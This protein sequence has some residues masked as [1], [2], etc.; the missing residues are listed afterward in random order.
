M[1]LFFFIGIK[2]W[3]ISLISQAQD[4]RIYFFSLVRIPNSIDGYF[5]FTHLLYLLIVPWIKLVLL[6]INWI[7]MMLAESCI[8]AHHLLLWISIETCKLVLPGLEILLVLKIKS[9]LILKAIL[10]LK[11]FLVLIEWRQ[12]TCGTYSAKSILL[13]LQLLNLL[14]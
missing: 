3:I 6:F 13:A 5:F 2:L 4:L 10:H 8:I 7:E 12:G 11:I 14:L 9:I 1:Q